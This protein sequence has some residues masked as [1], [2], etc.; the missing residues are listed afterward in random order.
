MAYYGAP[1]PG[2]SDYSSRLSALSSPGEETV[3]AALRHRFGAGL[4][5]TSVS[6]SNL[7]S[8][9]PFSVSS[10]VNSSNNDETLRAYTRY[11]RDTN[12]R[13]RGSRLPP[14]IFDVACNA[15]FYMQRTGQD[16]S[17]VFTGETASGKSELRRLAIRTLVALAAAAPGKRGAKLAHQIPSAEFILECFG[18]A[19]TSQNPNASR[20]GRYTELHFTDAGRLVGSK[21]LEYYLEKNRLV[22]A[23]GSEST[24]HAFYAL[25][26]GASAEE[27]EHLRVN[28]HSDFRYLGGRRSR[29]AAVEDAERFRK[30][31]QAFKNVG[32]SQRQVASI[33]QVLA[34]ILHLGNLEFGQDH[35]STSEAVSVRN[36]DV[37]AMV[38]QFLG[39]SARE[40]EEC[41]AFR[42]QL[43]RGE[44][45]TI[46]LDAEG[47][48]HNRDQL[49][50]SLY[51]LLFAWINEHL[52]QKLCSNNYDTY[53]GILDLPGPQ[54]NARGN[55]LDAFC[56]NMAN[57]RLHKWVLHSVFESK[58][59]EYL[60]EDIVRMAPEV[61]YPDNAEC[62][63]LLTN[64]PGGL[65]HI[66]DDQAS[67]KP[68][69]TDHTMVEAF[70]KR[71][72]N[73]P[74]FRVG[75]TNRDGFSSF[76][77]NHYNGPVTYSSEGWLD[78]NSEIISPNFVNLFRGIANSRRMPEPQY[79]DDED[80]SELDG[81]SSVPFVRSLFKSQSLQTQSHARS[82][83]TIVAAQQ[84]VKPL[85]GPSMRVPNRAGTIKRHATMKRRGT[86][87]KVNE[88][89]DEEYAE[90]TN[91]RTA[92]ETTDNQVGISGLAGQFRSALDTLFE[93]LDDT[94]PWIVT[95]LRPND[96]GLPNQLESRLVSQQI[97]SHCIAEMAS[98]LTHEYSVG[99]THEE[100][101]E[102]YADNPSLS[103]VAM[104]EAQG[105]TARQKFAN[106]Q[107]V[108]SWSEGDAVS[109]RNKVFLS[110]ETFRELEDE[111]RSMD[112]V[113]VANSK[114]RA[115]MDA[116]AAMIA[117]PDPFSPFG[118]APAFDAPEHQE[119]QLYSD[120]FK[121]RSSTTLPFIGDND[122]KSELGDWQGRPS[123]PRAMSMAASEAYAPSQNMF[124]GADMQEKSGPRVEGKQPG[125]VAEEVR[126]TAA[127]KQWVAFT[128]ML[129][130]CVP[131]FTLSRLGRMTRPD[132]KMA[133]REKLAINLMIWFICGCAVFV[134]AVLGNIICPT[135]HVYSQNE[136][137]GHSSDDNA[138]TAIRGE[139]FDLTDIVSMHRSVISVVPN[140]RI[141]QYAGIDS[142]SLFPVQV[143]ALCNGVTGT[144]SPWVQLSGGNTTDK[145]AQYHD[146]RSFHTDDARPDWYL[147]SMVLLRAN[148]RVGWMGYDSDD[149]DSLLS[150]GHSVAKYRG[151][152]YDVTD[153]VKQGNRGTITAPNGT[154]VSADIDASFMSNSV[155]DLIVQ[156]PGKDIT[157][158]FDSLALD[159]EVLQRQRTCLRNLF[160]IGKPDERNSARCQFSRY[161]LLALSIIMVSIIGFKFLAAL[162]F[163]RVRKPE[164]HDRFV[165]C[166]I[167][168]YTEGEESMRKTIDSLTA[169]KYDDKRKLLFVICDG[170]IVG[171]GNDRPTPRIVLDILGVDPNHDPEAL[172]FL[173]VG[174]GSKQHNM[175]KVYSGLYEHSGHVVPYVV[176]VKVGKPTEQSRP[177][178]RGKRDSQLVLMR[179]LNKV[180]FA[181]AMNPME[182]EIYHQIKNVIGVNPS[183]YEYLLQVDADTTVEPFA[184]SHFVSAFI[185]DK[186]V[187]GMCGE[188]A[189]SNSKQSFVTMLQVYEYYISHYL[190]KAF[191]SLFGSVTCLPGCFSMFRLRSPDTH[192]PLFI[193]S[194]VVEDYSENRV[195]TLHTKN[196]LSLG[197]DRYLTTLVLK[198]FGNYKTV[199]VRA[200]KA[201]TAAPDDMKVLLSQRRRWINSTIH[202]LVELLKTPGLC[203]FCL[204][205][206]RFIVFIDLLSTI[207]APVTVAY[208]VYLVILVTTTN[209]TVPTTSLIM[210]AAIYGLQAFIFILNRKFEM[211]GWMIV[212]IIGIPIWSF[213]LP[214]YSFWHMDDFSWGNTR[215]VLGEQGQKVVVHDEGKFR[216]SDIPLQTWEDYEN[217]LWE[218]NSG[219]SIGDILHS[220][221][222]KKMYEA[223]KMGS[224]M[225]LGG[226]GGGGG[227]A[228]MY[229]PSLYE[230]TP[231]LPRSGSYANSFGDMSRATS[232]GGG[233]DAMTPGAGVPYD[234]RM[235]TYSFGGGFSA[236]TPAMSM[237][238]GLNYDGAPAAGYPGQTTPTYGA[239]GGYG[240]SMPS[241]PY[242]SGMTM[243]QST[244]Q[245]D[246]NNVPKL[247]DI[248]ASSIHLAPPMPSDE[249]I[250]R[251]LKDMIAAAD[252]EMVSRKTLRTQ[253]EQRYGGVDLSSKREFIKA[254]IE[255]ILNEADGN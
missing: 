185:N 43:L 96:N 203:G 171:S 184:L 174:E 74:S 108:M 121:E 85:R 128:W 182:L 28:A 165:I 16:Q 196:L 75:S 202:N 254:Q 146:F 29:E 251:D 176:V 33:C 104:H 92:A 221:H 106:A 26:A 195:D 248:S 119:T 93:T 120:P 22:S 224:A 180:H 103:A 24:F 81:G 189:L 233:L 125:E 139:V 228:S 90:K 217:E 200:G 118:P 1:T 183:F 57:E 98:K 138:W 246:L 46:V 194:R 137:T 66:M 109:G 230:Q 240:S 129:T 222:H 37:L 164:N 157:T 76:T 114:K 8:I 122:Q 83:Q 73:N 234:P 159:P 197:E 173:S 67:R 91:T 59:Q 2:P 18:H 50:K 38:S 209:Q 167:P 63:R 56:L 123:I 143:S 227:G 252:L 156:N 244:S 86:D 80:G 17:V 3:L 190:A 19:S 9:N 247:V 101:C 62:L 105:H 14:H 117:Q 208:L 112:P 78:R 181:A 77:V 102:R 242:S 141:L 20:F 207:I 71:W 110:H 191:E 158:Q 4:T 13:A 72:A 160:Y 218:R 232:F 231:M 47:A 48:A 212:Y 213:F 27:K 84:P 39:V 193:A 55:S 175:A 40:L 32:L 205:S 162:Q 235:S 69:K 152:L 34:A 51:S 36:G 10:N 229:E 116:E 187:V 144:V 68:K 148:Y 166:Q 15:Y 210:L 60:H 54:D 223:S 179:F 149:I 111:L 94:K 25:I 170:N 135:Q 107:E 42:A 147:E 35:R 236:P 178:N 161:I 113:E 220:A 58:S 44:V 151:E 61:P 154:D 198:H 133:W 204:F 219:R 64:Q 5:Y 249:A 142:T 211:I 95:C 82:E 253:L 169:L 145:N 255:R 87:E 70:G 238:G 199:F 150:S 201:Y 23:S 30:M 188:T 134:I 241:R 131:S 49:A 168:C 215:V 153:Y 21:S 6:D 99:M 41:L 155:I 214:L 31:K 177:G 45:C 186:K 216:E 237:Y 127:R 172:S 245:H 163:S 225:S 192:R 89:S 126:E 11:S 136:L 124:A 132:I 97:R 226:G 239:P 250:T 79:D 88:G 140:K 7:V 206:M 52:N 12:R 130:C 65:V 243:M 53:I 115:Q 100:F